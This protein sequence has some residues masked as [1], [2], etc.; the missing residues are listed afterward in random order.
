MEPPTQTQSTPD[1]T[2]LSIH[3]GR[4]H[5][6][7]LDGVEGMPWLDCEEGELVEGGL[8]VFVSLIR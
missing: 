3:F 6:Y 2:P 1:P 7:L 8:E 5:D 4:M